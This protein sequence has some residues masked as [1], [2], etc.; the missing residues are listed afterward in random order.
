MVAEIAEFVR[1]G[2]PRSWY[3][4]L[5]PANDGLFIYSSRLVQVSRAWA[6]HLRQARIGDLRSVRE[7]LQTLHAALGASE[8][9]LYD[10]EAVAPGFLAGVESPPDP[11]QVRGT[12]WF[13][14]PGDAD[15]NTAEMRVLDGRP[16]WIAI[17]RRGTEVV[18]RDHAWRQFHYRAGAVAG[19]ANDHG[20]LLRSRR[21]SLRVLARLFQSSLPAR[22]KNAVTQFFRNG[23][24]S[25]SYYVNSGWVFVVEPPGELATCYHKESIA[26][27]GYT[28]VD[29]IEED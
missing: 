11:S 10:G 18:I 5:G 21:Y 20:C 28:I 7:L 9:Y 4:Q 29:E 2:C 19:V 27:A 23:M 8:S 16:G 17:R 12:A 6:R 14:D 26:E 13:I 22:R 3:R 15:F 25:A 24:R 1:A